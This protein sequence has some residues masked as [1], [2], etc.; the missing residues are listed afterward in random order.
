MHGEHQTPGGSLDHRSHRLANIVL[1]IGARSRIVDV[2][3]VSHDIYPVE[4]P[5]LAIPDGS[6]AHDRVGID[7]ELY[8]IHVGSP[9]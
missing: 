3:L 2:Q 5:L 8:L 7:N 6:F 9:C 1:Q 4:H